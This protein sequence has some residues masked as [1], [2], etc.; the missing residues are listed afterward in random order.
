M[1]TPIKRVHNSEKTKEYILFTRWDY[2]WTNVKFGGGLWWDLMQKQSNYIWETLMVSDIRV[3]V[4]ISSQY[5]LYLVLIRFHKCIGPTFLKYTCSFDTIFV[6]F[7]IKIRVFKICK[8]FINSLMSLD[9]LINFQK[10][11]PD[12]SPLWVQDTFL[13]EK[14]PEKLIPSKIIVYILLSET[15]SQQHL[16]WYLLLVFSFLNYQTVS[17][18]WKIL[19][20]WVIWRL[21]LYL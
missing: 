16:I 15:N 3:L 13:T 4:P 8:L 1:F 2:S 14:S 21:V 6:D 9:N 12:S 17:W 5:S 20:F 10:L 18:V 11:T 19:Q 7:C